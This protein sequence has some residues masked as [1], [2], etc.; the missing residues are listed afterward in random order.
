MPK[1]SKRY[2][3]AAKLV[4]LEKLYALPE[5]LELV[6][7]TGRAKFDAGV[8]LHLRLGINPKMADQIVRGTVSLPH[9]TGKSVR[10]AVFAEGAAAKAAKDAGADVV[11]GPELIKEVKEKSGLHV[12]VCVAHPAMMK[13]LGQVAKILGPRGL[14]PNPKNETVSEDV[15]KIVKELKAG[16]LT[17]RSDETGNLHVLIGRVTS[18]T[19]QLL[20]NAETFLEAVRRARP[21]SAKG[22]FFGNATLAATMGPPVRFAVS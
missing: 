6:K 13:H 22:T 3:E 20:A 14:M 11:G 7:K 17:F 1:R 21:A 4:D 10:V 2:R 5:A 9:A 16:R 19:S 18:E 15:A 12:D 8:E